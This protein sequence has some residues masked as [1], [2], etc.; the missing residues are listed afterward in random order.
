M[1]DRWRLNRAGITNVYQYADETLHFGGGRL[2]LRGVNGSGKST[3]MNMLLPFLLDAD[4]RRIDAAGEQ[5]SVLRSWMLTGRDELQ[6]VGYLWIEFE[7]DGADDA[8]GAMHLVCGCGIRAN[9]SS[10]RVNTWWFITDRRPGVD[11]ALVEARV[12]LSVEALR[13]ELGHHA[14][15]ADTQR[16]AYRQAV[17]ERLF[18][19]RELDQH[20]RLLHVVRSPRV[21]DRID[22]ELPD[23]L[24]DALP[25]LSETALDDAAQPLEDLD[26]HR[27]N[28][29]ELTRTA[30]ALEALAEVYRAYAATDLRGRAE[31][32]VTLSDDVTR[33][34]QTARRAGRDAE[35]AAAA[36]VAA[37]LHADQLG[38]DEARL[39][40]EIAALEASPAYQEG[41]LLDDLRR[42]VADLQTALAAAQ[43]RVVRS[44]AKVATAEAAL[45]HATVT[46]EA[47]VATV[48]A[49]LS[50]LAAAAAGLRFAAR[51]P[52]APTFQ[53]SGVL[54]LAPQRIGLAQ[55]RAARQQRQVDV[56]ELDAALRRVEAC[57]T[58]CERSERELSRRLD[59]QAA[60]GRR[61]EEARLRL[62]ETV[63][64]WRLALHA[65]ITRVDELDPEREVTE[66]DPAIVDVADLLDRRAEVAA[67]LT[68]AVDRL[69]DHHG[70]QRAQLTAKRRAEVAAADQLEAE[71]EQLAN[72]THPVPPAAPWQRHQRGPVL[73]D[74]ID[75]ADH[76]SEN[77]RRGLEGAMEAAGLLGAE[78][79]ADGTLQ[80]SDGELVVVAGD[81]VSSPLSRLLVPVV[82][83]DAMG[84]VPGISEIVAIL[85]GLGTDLAAGATA[86]VVATDGRFRI[87]ALSGR[88]LKAEA[89]HIGVTARRAAI[90]RRRVQLA[91]E[92]A[93]LRADIERT[94]L[95]IA[96][97][98]AVIAA[99]RGARTALPRP[100]QVT[101]A[102]QHAALADAQLAAAA[103]RTDEARRRARSAEVALGDATTAM[104]RTAFTH[105]LPTDAAAL[106]SV[107]GELLAAAATC[108]GIDNSL[109]LLARS[110]EA[111]LGQVA[112]YGEAVAEL[113]RTTSEAA[114]ATETV[115][116]QAMRLATLEDSIG[117]A[118]AEI[119]LAVATSTADLTRVRR[120]SSV[121]LAATEEAIA[122]ET[123]LSVVAESALGDHEASAQ[124]CVAAISPLRRALEVPGLLDAAAATGA[125]LPAVEAD[126]A[127]ARTL[128]EALL[129][130]VAAPERLGVGADNV[131]QSLRARRDQLGAGWDAEDLQPDPALPLAV[132]VTGPSGRL[133]L[134]PA[135]K[136]VRAQLDQQTGLLTAKQDQALRN[137][138]QGLVAREVAEKMHA[139][140][141][142]VQLMNRQLDRVT[143]AHG[144]GARLTWKRRND[145]DEGLAGMI[146]LLAMP[147]DLRT[148]EHDTQLAA[149]L[150]QRLEGGR[151]LDPER[152]YRDLIAEV[153]DYRGW[154]EMSVIVRR[155]GRGDEKLT[156]RTPLSEGEKKIVSY[157][158]LFAAVA[159]SYDA[160]GETEPA[161]PRF[162][163]LDDAFAKVSED[164]HAQLFGLLVQLDLDF[165]AT[166][167][168]LWG[169]HGTVPELAIT[170]VL[171]DAELGVIV[172]EH[173]RWDG[174]TRSVSR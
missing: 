80:L 37:R 87:G 96:A 17:R 108:D 62:A 127:G 138:L 48:T 67:A 128:A 157:L 43:Q 100:D 112:S 78:V 23:Y 76:V 111:R 135:S 139:A 95:D 73:A 152:R 49:G 6:P 120:E 125:N 113:E 33:A 65:W 12:P 29:H 98:D 159:A 81:P 106:A 141:E 168:R 92:L 68:R 79:L 132:Q 103:E 117:V 9:R 86:T 35:E 99:I 122:T 140:R 25:Q 16:S 5:S 1:T 142:L 161:T 101:E 60:A 155:P 173:S 74:L 64:E 126:P 27:R 131:R 19:G 82:P 145:L 75:F 72:R 102:A 105:Q 59:E 47:D 8:E 94:E 147:P 46:V 36:L 90:E 162:V 116:P 107:R 164:N 77:A 20:F 30:N 89:E 83:D 71:L 15:F 14:V 10:D 45:H 38:L 42:H 3:A 21:G 58:E 69:V 97:A 118:Y 109:V 110:H 31:H 171:R 114:A 104:E 129:V 26:E 88:H 151:Q 160:I 144:I 148:Q 124:R 11:L 154:H 66:L 172:L 52:D 174:A 170:E 143:T 146:E 167:E 2:L 18:G 123:R 134:A 85:D 150:S 163:L 28:V 153:L 91:T 84:A 136:R 4:V 44:T 121:A 137:L 158:P 166:S 53:D 54:D 13:A 24:N 61:L 56:D 51:P 39:R 40:E 149:A 32:L 93:E 22:S 169:T 50:D 133:P 70:E 7:R 119:L 41:H 63:A 55:V 130:C 57:A 156:R 165:I 34:A 115:E